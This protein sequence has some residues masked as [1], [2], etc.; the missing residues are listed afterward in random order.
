MNSSVETH[1]SS[2]LMWIRQALGILGYGDFNAAGAPDPKDGKA[3]LTHDQQRWTFEALNRFH[4]ALGWPR[5]SRETYCMVE[6][7]RD[8][9][10]LRRQLDQL[11]HM[12]AIRGYP[13]KGTV[14]DSAEHP[15]SLLID[16]LNQFR[17][18]KLPRRKPEDWP[19]GIDEETRT[20]FDNTPPYTEAEVLDHELDAILAGREQTQQPS[21]ITVHSVSVPLIERAHQA[22]LMGLA[23]SGGGIRSA[24][25]NL[26]ILQGLASL[27]LLSHFDYLSTVSGGGYIG[28]WLHAWVH[29]IGPTP[30]DPAHETGKSDD[31]T[32]DSG[33]RKVEE[34]LCGDGG[35]ERPEISWLR[36][37]SNYLAP[38]TSL[39]S[40]DI[41]T[42]VVTWARNVILNQSILMLVLVPLLIVP[43]LYTSALIW[44]G[45]AGLN[46]DNYFTVSLVFAIYALCCLAVGSAY[47]G[48]ES[49]RI[50]Y[51]D[52]VAGKGTVLADA[53]TGRKVCRSFIASGLAFAFALSIAEP[54]ELIQDNHPLFD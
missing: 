52:L 38:K 18:D 17:C 37:Y 8:E 47:A 33:I 9:T 48:Y 46:V 45:Q 15:A 24:T 20:L 7:E 23:F 40:G 41:M 25:F 54:L 3:V 1:D 32:V 13:V 12:L 39:F 2:C 31:S 28:G 34:A 49:A 11:R 22:R 21:S 16:T 10:E 4:N 5:C 53:G 35:K 43:W 30:A 27:G 6:R 26:G 29:R 42:G 19:A 44:Q 14:T 51:A 36:R 50:H